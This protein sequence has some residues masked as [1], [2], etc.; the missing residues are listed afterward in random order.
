MILKWRFG[1]YLAVSSLL[2]HS[3][4]SEAELVP[5]T[6]KQTLIEEMSLSLVPCDL[7][8]TISDFLFR[9]SYISMFSFGEYTKYFDYLTSFP[10]VIPNNLTD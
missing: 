8:V 7:H 9:T 10:L 1:Y 5:A 4:D 3:D 2:L 6:E